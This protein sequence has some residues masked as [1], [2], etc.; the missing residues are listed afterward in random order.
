MAVDFQNV[1]KQFVEYY[2]KTFDTNRSALAALYRDQ[3]MLTFEAAP[4]Q[5]AQQITQKLVEL[6]FQQVEHQVATLDAQPSNESGGILVTVS[7]AL[8][9]EAEKRPMSYTQT[10]QLLP[11]G[12][13]YFIF[14][15]IFRLVYP[16]A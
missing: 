5:G 9:V 10:F 2:Y 4:T 3:S 12:G 6:P 13:S 8:L 14:N 15:D 16:A 7:G 1:A 11:E